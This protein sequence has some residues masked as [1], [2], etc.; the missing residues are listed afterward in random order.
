MATQMELPPGEPPQLPT[1]EDAETP[2]PSVWRRIKDHSWTRTAFGLAVLAAI[3]GGLL[4][5]D[6]LGDD[7]ATVLLDSG[8]EIELG[9]Q[10]GSSPDVGDAAPEFA[11]LDPDGNVHQLSDF[12]GQVVWVNFWATWCG[13][14][15]R[16]L[17]DIQQLANEFEDQGLV[18]LAVNQ[19]QSG[20]IANDF[21]EELDL[22]LP[23]LLDSNGDVTEQY[24]LR[25][26]P[27]N[28]FIDADGVLRGGGLGFL[29]EEQMRE[30]LAE[31]GLESATLLR[32]E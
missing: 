10:D 1:E 20:E 26:L 31:A 28:F 14:C 5:V 13:P 18:V 27:N 23:I 22:D 6:R 3:M 2:E 17:P 32:G 24:R 30:L 21:W 25:G 9:A 16:E 19:R 29:T 4:A 15:R 8:V 7:S 12:R 11:L